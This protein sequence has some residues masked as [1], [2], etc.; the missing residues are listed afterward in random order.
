M[1][2][3]CYVV[4]SPTDA[5]TLVIYLKLSS[6]L[7]PRA[8]W[9]KSCDP[10]AKGEGFG[11]AVGVLNI[12]RHHK[13]SDLD[14]MVANALQ[15]FSLCL[16]SA[17]VQRSAVSGP[18]GCGFGDAHLPFYERVQN[19]SVLAR[20][21]MGPTLKFEYGMEVENGEWESGTENIRMDRIGYLKHCRSVL[22]KFRHLGG[23]MGSFEVASFSIGQLSWKGGELPKKLRSK[24]LYNL[25]G[26]R[27]V[28]EETRTTCVHITLKGR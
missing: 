16:D 17:G 25:L 15:E 7:L 3:L 21:F 14:L 1:Y 23:A 5:K 22:S 8:A 24:N 2:V 9:G 20:E 10:K 11:L 13:L 19:R 6:H 18:G 27:T 12:L 26:E 4:H 28:L